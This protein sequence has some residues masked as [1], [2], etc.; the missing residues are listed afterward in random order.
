[1]HGLGHRGGYFGSNLPPKFQ[2][3]RDTWPLWQAKF[4]SFA[5]NK[6][7][8]DAYRETSNRV[9]VADDVLTHDDLLL[10]HSVTAIARA[11]MA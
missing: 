10:R 1:M 4:T 5:G 6:G 11:R 3:Q 8:R 2:N 9:L 7:A